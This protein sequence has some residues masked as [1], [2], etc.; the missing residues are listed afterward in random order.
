[1]C[2]CFLHVW[3]QKHSKFSRKPAVSTCTGSQSL[4]FSP[5]LNPV[6]NTWPHY[7]CCASA[8]LHIHLPLSELRITTCFAQGHMMSQELHECSS[9]CSSRNQGGRPR[10]QPFRPGALITV[11]S[12]LPLSHINTTNQT[13][14]HIELTIRHP[15]NYHN[16]PRINTKPDFSIQTNK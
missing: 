12:L 5:Y 7:C 16:S 15:F 10:L 3:S 4:I 8:A 1:M 13:A 14:H 9:V 11:W 2:L 6:K